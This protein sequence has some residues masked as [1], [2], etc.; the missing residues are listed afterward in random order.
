M[1][2]IFPKK[3]NKGFDFTNRSQSVSHRD[4]DR[5]GFIQ[6]NTVK[7]GTEVCNKDRWEVDATVSRWLAGPVHATTCNAL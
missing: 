6:I 7:K 1:P 3:H 2:K 4:K 5:L